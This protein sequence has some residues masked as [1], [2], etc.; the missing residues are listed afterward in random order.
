ME[1]EEVPLPSE[2]LFEENT[3]S[4][5]SEIPIAIPDTPVSPTK[6]M[7]AIQPQ[8][9][10]EDDQEPISFERSVD[11]EFYQLP[12]IDL[13]EEIPTKN[14]AGERENV[15]KN[16]QILERTLESFKISA[17]VESAV[18]GPSVTKYEIKLATGVKVSRVVNLSDDLAL[19]LAAK[20]V[21]IEA[22]IPCE[23]P[24]RYRNP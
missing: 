21:R 5:F 15:R 13:L 20:D 3:T 14:Q 2:P 4:D 10:V 22:P 9:E 19:A 23:I 6:E 8:E 11:N 7:A 24:Y 18:V 17:S 12:T 16:I 1:A